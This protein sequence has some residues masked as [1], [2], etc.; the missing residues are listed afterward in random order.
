[1]PLTTEQL[2]FLRRHKIGTSM[3]MDASG[4]RREDYDA[5][6]RQQD[7]LFAFG[8]TPCAAGHTLRSRAGHCIQCNTATISFMLRHHRRATVYIAASRSKRLV[9][10]GLTTDIA[11]REEQLRKYLYA[12]ADDWIMVSSV[13]CENAG[14]VEASAHTKLAA[15]QAQSRYFWDGQWRDCYEVFRCGYFTAHRAVMEFLNEEERAA[16]MRT[17]RRDAG[18]NYNFD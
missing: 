17:M 13:P 14:R 11:A 3:V 16:L 6:M 2:L 9:K 5:R 18:V 1:M 4:Y 15:H 7:K 8:V 10:I 12:E